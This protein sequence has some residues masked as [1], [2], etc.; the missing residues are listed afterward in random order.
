M[1]YIAYDY[2]NNAEKTQKFTINHDIL[3]YIDK[4]VEKY[5]SYIDQATNIS[6]SISNT[7]IAPEEE[8]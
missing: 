4:D 2:M 5:Y 1:R 6:T 3:G 7:E 8:I